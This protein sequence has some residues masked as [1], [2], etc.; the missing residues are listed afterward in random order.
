MASAYPPN[1]YWYYGPALLSNNSIYLIQYIF[2]DSFIFYELGCLYFT[3]QS[4]SVPRLKIF[5]VKSVMP[6]Q[7][8]VVF[9]V[10]EGYAYCVR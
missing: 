8:I 1:S 2:A 5:T 7:N 9:S 4:A 10:K 6:I 3:V